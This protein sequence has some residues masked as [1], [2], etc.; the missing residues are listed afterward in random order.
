M[1]DPLRYVVSKL[2]DEEKAKEAKAAQAVEDEKRAK[3]SKG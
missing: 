2:Q 1:S 3:E